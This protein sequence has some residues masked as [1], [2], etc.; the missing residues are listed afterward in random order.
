MPR[1][2]IEAPPSG[3]A[4]ILAGENAR[5]IARA[6]RMQPGESLT[7]CDGSGTD[8]DCV[9]EHAA[10]DEVQARVVGTHASAGEPN[11]H[12]TLYMA[13]PKADKMEFIVQKATEL[14]VSEIA[15]FVS[16]RCVSRPDERALS[17]K[18]ARW[19]KIAAEAAKQC[20][21]GRIPQV[22]QAVPMTFAVEQAAE[23]GLALL[24]YEGE[25]ENSLRRVLQAGVPKTVSFLVGPEGGF[26]PDEAAAAIT[27]GL[28]SVSLGPRVL[29]CETAPL[30]ALS[31]IM[32]ES[33]N[34]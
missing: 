26:T 1:F 32:Y 33:S 10:A 8:Y 5:H 4:V 6:L 30:A 29:R 20:G 11:I 19:G 34:L 23:A 28:R 17:K 31:A 13:M 9:L 16:S 24:L 3:N 27:A 18:C 2:F 22:R 21:R 7:V 14:G 25:R 12:V 15:P